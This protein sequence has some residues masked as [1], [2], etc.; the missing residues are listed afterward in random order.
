[1]YLRHHWRID[2]LG[3][4]IYSAA[5]FS[6]FYKSLGRMDKAYLTGV[7]GGNGWQ[8]L[9]EGTRLQYIFDRRPEIKGNYIHLE[10]SDGYDRR[11]SVDQL[12]EERRSTDLESAWVNDLGL[13]W[14]TRDPDVNSYKL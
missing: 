2:L 8:R 5:V 10:D 6:I 11:A 13:S 7:S 14:K 12:L 9:F 1:M 4:L 3:G